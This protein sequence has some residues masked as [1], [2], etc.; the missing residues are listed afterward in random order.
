MH[1][2]AGVLLA[3][4][5]LADEFSGHFERFGPSTVERLR[6]YLKGLV[7]A[8]KKNMERM[9][10]AVP[11]ADEQRLQHFLSN[12][13]W[14]YKAVIKQVAAGVDAAIGDPARAGLLLD[15][16]AYP[17]KGI[18]SVG[19]SRQ[20]CGNLGKVDNCPV[21]VFAVLSRDQHAAPVDVRL[22]LPRSWTDCE[23]RCNRAGVPFSNQVPKTKLDLA[24][25]MVRDARRN[26]LR[27][28][29]VGADAFYGKN[30]EFLR[31]LDREGE[32]FVADVNKNQMVFLD[33]PKPKATVSRAT[34]KSTYRSP[35][36]ATRVDVWA[37]RQHVKAWQRLVVRDGTKGPIT[38]EVLHRSVWVWDR[39]E[40]KA[41]LWRLIVRREVDTPDKIKYTL[42]NASPEVSVKQLAYWQGQRYWVERAFQDGK[43][44]VG[45]G[46]YQ[47][48]GWRPWHH[49]ASLVMMA[50]LFLLRER[51]KHKR[52]LPLLSCADVTGLL[53]QLVSEPRTLQDSLAQMDKRHRKRRAAIDSARRLRG[54]PSAASP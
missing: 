6:E 41:H 53:R 8:R 7:A 36:K 18:Y 24:L 42:S 32:C 27:Y 50:M 10:E 43:T 17:K 20:W 22:F 23:P 39:E 44:E 5:A 40:A 47:A 48:R 45:M 25:E 4:L 28:A 12:V 1:P 38:V 19:V 34:G 46:D 11:G 29:W 33:D 49:H 35:A 9:E 21:A 14:D 16:T 30:P 52:V 54:H 37:N 15:E 31:T 13:D 26:G 51:L 3:L 2:L